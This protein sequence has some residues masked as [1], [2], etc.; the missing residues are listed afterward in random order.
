MIEQGA[1]LVPQHCVA[2][3]RTRELAPPGAKVEVECDTLDQVRAAIDAGAD[4]VLVDNMPLDAIREAVE[5][6]RGR[7][8]VEASGGV[9]IDNVRAIAETGVDFISV[10]ALTHSPPA[11]NLALDFD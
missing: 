5:M 6:A 1:K 7:A 8:T 3:L 9:T 11:M 4:E 10:G 2:L